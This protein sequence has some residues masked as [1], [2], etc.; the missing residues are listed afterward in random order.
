MGGKK[1]RERVADVQVWNQGNWNS[2]YTLKKKR[3]GFGIISYQN[4]IYVIGGNDG[5]NIL[6]TM[7]ILNVLTG[8]WTKAEP[9]T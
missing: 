7:E 1:G 4:F 3:S 8:E 2:Q 9:M 6:N 5:E